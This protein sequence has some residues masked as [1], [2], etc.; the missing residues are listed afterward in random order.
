MQAHFQFAQASAYPK[1]AIEHIYLPP[2]SCR[3]E[4]QNKARNN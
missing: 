3:P 1:V 4:K 2:L